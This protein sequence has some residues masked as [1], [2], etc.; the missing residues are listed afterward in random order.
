[1]KTAELKILLKKVGY[2][3]RYAYSILNGSPVG[4]K[5]AILLEAE[6]GVDRKVW[7]S[8]SEFKNPLLQ[9]NS[10]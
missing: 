2:A 8:P 6:T 10:K 1:M 3:E 9:V 4:K 7:Q 5:L